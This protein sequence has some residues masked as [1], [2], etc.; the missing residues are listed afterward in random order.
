MD[1]LAEM[2][3]NAVVVQRNL[4]AD[5]ATTMKRIGLLHHPKLP[6]TQPMAE[7]MAC[8][9]EAQGLDAWIGSTWDEDTVATEIARLDLL[10]TLGGDGSILRA[11]RMASER[12]VPVLGVKMGRLGFLAELD[13]EQWGTAL[14]RLLA[15]EYW[16][17]KRMM[18]SAEYHRGEECR[19]YEALNDVVI[20]RG[21]LARI[22]RLETHIDGSYLTTYAADGLIVSTATGSTAYALAVGGPILPPQLENILLIPIAPHL[23]MS[24]AI[25]LGQGDE[26]EVEVHTDHQAILT[27][28]GQFEYDL[29]DGD[30]VRVQASPHSS[31]FVHFQDRAYF[32]RTLMDRLV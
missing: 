30:W 32:Y 28:D 26:V 20:S 9:A 21:S 7:G 14:A 27:V 18:L 19:Q 24:R 4:L 12:G 10:V 5:E 3:Y 2:R 15:G 8:A 23:S 17:E 1:R 16:L 22:V 31:Y 13:P 6:A 29:Q 25:V 11:A